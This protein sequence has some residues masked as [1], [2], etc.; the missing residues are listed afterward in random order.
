MSV[1]RLS[2]RAFYSLYNKVL[3]H[4]WHAWGVTRGAAHVLKTGRWAFLGSFGQLW[5]ALSGEL[6]GALG[7]S[8]QLWGALPGLLGSWAAGA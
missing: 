4:G 6:W 1:F 5:G 8:G 7:S 2:A 3:I